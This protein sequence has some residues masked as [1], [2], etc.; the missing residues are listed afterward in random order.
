MSVRRVASIRMAARLCIAAVLLAAIAGTASAAEYK[1]GFV[2][3]ERLF[4]E[5]TPAKRAQA[6][7]EKEFATRDAEIQ[8]LAKQVRDLQAALDRDGAT[9]ADTDRRNKERDLA[10][11]TRDLQRMQREFR[12]DIN[13]RKNEEISALQ[14]RANKV[15]QQIAESEKYDLILQDPVVYA[16][17][18][19]DITD[20]VI[21]ALADK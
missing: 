21:K 3:T 18:R 4:R 8:K 6:K 16:S 5:A 17:Q 7:I 13:L 14:E 19:I 2:N 11:Q 12:E 15:I 10:N 20:K 9:M 1:I